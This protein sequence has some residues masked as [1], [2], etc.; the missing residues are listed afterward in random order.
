M[1]R[2]WIV[3]VA[4]VLAMGSSPA[5]A[6]AGKPPIVLPSQ[7]TG[8]QAPVAQPE[9]VDPVSPYLPQVTCS[10]VDMVGPTMLRDLL[11]TTYGVGR[12]AGI[13]R[14]CTEGLSEHSEGR[15]LDW[16]VD[17]KNAAEKAA[18]ADFLAWVT[19]DDGVNAR[20][21]GIMYVIYNKKIWSVY[22]MQAG[23]RTSA[24]HTDHVHV[25]FSWNGARGAT[26]FWTGAVAATDYGPCVRF[27]GSYAV[28]TSTARATR[29]GAP[30]S[31]LVRTTRGNRA[32]GSSGGTVKRAQKLLK[33]AVTGRFTSSTRSAVKT[34]Q[35]AHDLPATGALDQ[36]TWASLDR[37]SIKKRVVTGFNRSR[38]AAHGVAHFS[39]RTMSKGRVGSDVLILQTAL[40]MRRADRNGYLGTVTVAAVVAVQKRAGLAADGVV[41]AEEWEAIRAATR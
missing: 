25:S 35:R 29:C 31:A 26:S 40:G 12:G 1:R 7:P 41:G 2:I 19:R 30:T 37:A 14:G 22:N 24:G 17:V 34:Y 27:K 28:P 18:A 39:G 32:Y 20:R 16:M 6:A 21:L 23:W 38:A 13:S 11:L 33:V 3:V 9:A 4:L 10:P 8:L 36:P 5:T 15:A